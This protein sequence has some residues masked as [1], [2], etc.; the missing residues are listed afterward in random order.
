MQTQPCHPRPQHIY[1]RI[2]T[3]TRNHHITTSL[4]LVTVAL[5]ATLTTTLTTSLHL[6]P[7]LRPIRPIPPQVLGLRESWNPQSKWGLSDLT[8]HLLGVAL[9]KEQRLS[10]WEGTLN[11]E[12]LDYVVLD[13]IIPLTLYSM[14]HE[15]STT[16]KIKQGGRA[17]LWNKAEKE[18]EGEEVEEVVE[19][20]EALPQQRQLLGGRIIWH[21]K[22]GGSPIGGLL[23]G[24]SNAKTN[25]IVYVRS[26][27]QGILQHV[28]QGEP[29]AHQLAI[30]GKGW[31]KVC[32]D[33]DPP[34]ITVWTSGMLAIWAPEKELVAGMTLGLSTTS[35]LA[36]GSERVIQLGDLGITRGICV[37]HS[38]RA[39]SLPPFLA[40]VSFHRPSPARPSPSPSRQVHCKR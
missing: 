33:D 18:G 38:E 23:L 19:V 22:G 28:E 7:H 8:R 36:E 20:D 24:R 9:K 32:L 25:E 13:G 14:L 39:P 17:V 30:M 21:H 16:F 40:A 6:S 26:D 27:G 12:Q 4:H 37:I 3:S 29:G 11:K 15:M 34:K 10:N 1:I 31:L 2:Y 35:H 5:N